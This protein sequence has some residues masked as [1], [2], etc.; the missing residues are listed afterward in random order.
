[1]IDDPA[2]QEGPEVVG[3]NDVE[4]A[5]PEFGE[6]TLPATPFYDV[7]QRGGNNPQGHFIGLIQ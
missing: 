4:Y 1:M 7:V 6:K 2:P 3:L 5:E